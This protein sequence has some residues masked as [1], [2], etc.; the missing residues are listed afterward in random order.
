MEQEVISPP[1]NGAA[2]KDDLVHFKFS[3]QQGNG[4]VEPEAAA[5]RDVDSIDPFTYSP[6]LRFLNY[7][8]A[9]KNKDYIS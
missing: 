9:S 3:S 6:T 8:K 5:V 2:F 7:V 1:A 4:K